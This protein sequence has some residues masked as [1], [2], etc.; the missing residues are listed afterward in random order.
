MYSF[1]KLKKY[2]PFVAFRKSSSNKIALH[3]FAKFSNNWLKVKWEEKVGGKEKRE[4]VERR[5]GVKKGNNKWRAVKNPGTLLETM[6]SARLT[7][8]IVSLYVQFVNAL[9]KLKA[10]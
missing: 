2:R 7:L 5:N 4:K 1:T 3:S 6:L 10:T 9:L 8:I